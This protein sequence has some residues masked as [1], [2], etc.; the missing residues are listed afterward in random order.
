[1]PLPPAFPL[2]PAL[3]FPFPPAFPLLP[4]GGGG[5]ETGVFFSPWVRTIVPPSRCA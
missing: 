1:L 4:G 3:P 2:P 5:G